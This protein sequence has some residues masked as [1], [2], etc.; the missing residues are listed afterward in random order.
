MPKARWST[1]Q[2]SPTRVV[3]VDR[4]Q[5]QLVSLMSKTVTNTITVSY[6]I[7]ATVTNAKYIAII[8]FTWWSYTIDL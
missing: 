7:N 6:S 2:Q 8:Q 3:N 1:S 5:T 4:Q